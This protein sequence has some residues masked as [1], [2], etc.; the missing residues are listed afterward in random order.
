M[1]SEKWLLIEGKVH[2]L[3]DVFDTEKEANSFALVLQENCHVSVYQLK[4]GKWAVYW[5][6]RSGILCPYGVV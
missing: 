5:R 2:K 1:T 3:V 6:P 4:D